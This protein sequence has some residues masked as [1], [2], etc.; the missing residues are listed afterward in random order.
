MVIGG[1]KEFC[2]HLLFHRADQ[3]TV[4]RLPSNEVGD[5]NSIMRNHGQYK[6]TAKTKPADSKKRYDDETN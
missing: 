2:P 3:S 5:E 1:I 4:Q 6:Q